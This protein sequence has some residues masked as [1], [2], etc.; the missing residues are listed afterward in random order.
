[1]LIKMRKECNCPELVGVDPVEREKRE[2]QLK[3]R[4]MFLQQQR[5]KMGTAS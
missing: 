1:M 2:Q 5:A 4:Q 3:R